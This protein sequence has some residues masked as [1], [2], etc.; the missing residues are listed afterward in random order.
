[1]QDVA[2]SKRKMNEQN[3]QR[4]YLHVPGQRVCLPHVTRPR[5]QLDRCGEKGRNGANHIQKLPKEH[6]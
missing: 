3:S 5:P 2:E 4:F 1:M 6:S